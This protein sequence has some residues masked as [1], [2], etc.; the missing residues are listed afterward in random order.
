MDEEKKGFELSR[1]LYKEFKSM[2]REKM[3]EVLTNIYLQGVQSVETSSVDL[4]RLRSEI[5]KINGIGEK[6]LDE[7]MKVIENA[8]N[9]S[10]TTRTKTE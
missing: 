1:A 5:G 3:Q 7:I 8:V 6:R 4:D 2:K 9:T 10:E